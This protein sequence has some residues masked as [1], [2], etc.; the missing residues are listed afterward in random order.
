MLKGDRILAAS[1]LPV[2]LTLSIHT[3]THCIT[4]KYWRHVYRTSLVVALNLLTIK[5]AKWTK[6]NENL[7][8]QCFLKRHYLHTKIFEQGWSCL[9][10]LAWRRKEM[11]NL[12]IMTPFTGVNLLFAG[13]SRCTRPLL[14]LSRF[15]NSGNTGTF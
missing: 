14:L 10:D 2:E 4:C 13:S 15:L 11:S 5:R 7:F 3:R 8:N 6:N 12:M 1:A 9:S